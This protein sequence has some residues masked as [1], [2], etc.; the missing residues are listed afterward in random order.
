MAKRIVTN[1]RF[2]AYLDKLCNKIN[3][4]SRIH[5]NINQLN[6]QS[7]LENRIGI[8]NGK[9]AERVASECKEEPV[10]ES[11]PY[12]ILWGYRDLLKEK[13]CP[14]IDFYSRMQGILDYAQNKIKIAQE[15][16][17][18]NIDVEHKLYE[19]NQNFGLSDLDIQELTRIED[20]H[21]ECSNAVNNYII[22]GNQ[23]LGHQ[24][25]HSFHQLAESKEKPIARFY[26]RRLTEKEYNL[27]INSS[28]EEIMDYLLIEWEMKDFDEDRRKYHSF[29]VYNWTEMPKENSMFSIQKKIAKWNKKETSEEEF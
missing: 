27:F 3:T 2:D 18:E 8:L 11:L 19:K 16:S 14:E 7:N 10:C 24:I 15:K 25:I 5:G 13:Q 12:V 28:Y 4:A 26:E 9:I 29:G 1:K 22:V 17:G 6:K 20:E 21:R 23:L